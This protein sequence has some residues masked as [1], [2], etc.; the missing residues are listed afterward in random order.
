MTL[1]G[2]LI[3]GA[4]MELSKTER[5]W[6]SYLDLANMTEDMIRSGSRRGMIDV[7]VLQV[8]QNLKLV[9]A[10]VERR[11]VNRVKQVRFVEAG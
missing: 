7:G 6:M 2:D 4:L 3:R 9:P 10:R 8:A 1:K 11:L 5:G